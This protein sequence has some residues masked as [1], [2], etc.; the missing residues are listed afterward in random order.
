MADGYAKPPYNRKIGIPQEYSW[1][2]LKKRR[3]AELETFY[4]LLLR[5]LALQKGMLGQIFTK[6]QNKIQDLAMLYLIRT[7]KKGNI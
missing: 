7:K 5:E 4:V 6:A 2:E 3:G 1:Q